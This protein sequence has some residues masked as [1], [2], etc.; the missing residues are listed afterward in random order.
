[1][2]THTDTGYTETDA[3]TGL[4]GRSTDQPTAD[5]VDPTRSSSDD[6]MVTDGPVVVDTAGASSVD[7]TDHDDRYAPGPVVGPDSDPEGWS[8]GRDDRSGAATTG[9]DPVADDDGPAVIA[10]VPAGRADGD[11]PDGRPGPTGG[12]EP[13]DRTDPN[14]P[15]RADA[16]DRGDREVTDGGPF[17]A[18]QG[19][20]VRERWRAVQVSFVDEPEAAV[21]QARRLVGDVADSLIDAIRQEGDRLAGDRADGTGERTEDLR[22]ALRRYRD[23]LDRLLAV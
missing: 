15:D 10:A 12:F 3:D 5:E 9:T 23:H 4:T 14:D 13:V 19:D 21:D 20:E 8:T 11:D 17:L 18:G 1:M 2:N 22:L 7:R 16:T 6:V